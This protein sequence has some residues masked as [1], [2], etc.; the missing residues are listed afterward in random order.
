MASSLSL[1]PKLPLP[2]V[3][4]RFLVIYSVCAVK[5]TLRKWNAS[6][7]AHITWA[8]PREITMFGFTKVFLV[9]YQMSRNQF[10]ISVQVFFL[11]DGLSRPPSGFLFLSVIMTF[12]INSTHYSGSWSLCSYL[13]NA[14]NLDSSM[15]YFSSAMES[16]SFL[17]LFFG[18]SCNKWL[19]AIKQCFGV[20][21]KTI[22]W[23]IKTKFKLHNKF[24]INYIMLV[25][26]Q[27]L[28]YSCNL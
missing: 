6:H 21:K 18:N 7:S 23:F 19:R 16:L 1:S 27:T 14:S 20:K 3:R 10:I 8:G 9:G 4:I 2:A 26:F 12:H 13:G 15:G 17:S 24:R 5:K 22:F 11:R 28:F 25:L